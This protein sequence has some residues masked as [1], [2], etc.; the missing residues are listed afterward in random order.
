MRNT[1]YVI[2]S[3]TIVC[4]KIFTRIL[5]YI[6]YISYIFKSIFEFHR[7]TELI[8]MFCFVFCVHNKI[9][10]S[11]L[12]VTKCACFDQMMNDALIFFVHVLCVCVFSG[13]WS[14]SCFVRIAYENGYAI[15]DYAK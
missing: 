15:C 14:F 12:Y 7:N 9:F 6:S 5:R 13:T 2:I 4:H 10:H 1:H 8:F 11:I 3:S